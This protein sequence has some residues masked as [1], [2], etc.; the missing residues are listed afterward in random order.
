MCL[1]TGLAEEGR[2]DNYS[3]VSHIEASL[4]PQ[5]VKNLPV[6]PETKGWEDALDKGMV[7]HS[8]ILAWRIPWTEDPGR[9][10]S[11]GQK[12]LDIAEQLTLSLFKPYR[13]R[14]ITQNG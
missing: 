4:V 7:T 10:Q 3:S 1:S 9:L 2:S 6:M 11:R 13:L 5:A 8:S 12:G 14:K